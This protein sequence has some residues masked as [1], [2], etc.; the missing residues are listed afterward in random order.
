[1]LLTEQRKQSGPLQCRIA[2]KLR[3]DL[4]PMVLKW[5]GAGG[6]GMGTLEMRRKLAHLF[7]FAGG[8]LAHPCAC[9]CE[10]LRG[11]F[12]SRFASIA[13]PRYPSSCDT[14]LFVVDECHRRSSME[15][16]SRL[17]ASIVRGDHGNMLRFAY[18]P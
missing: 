5:I 8:A 11:P 2:F 17:M 10:L 7:I 12:T 16:L 3:D 18:L 1:M 4:G 13:L 9:S 15:R 14:H 6:P